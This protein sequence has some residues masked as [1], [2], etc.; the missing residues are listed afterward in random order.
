MKFSYNV[1]DK[2][3]NEI[4]HDKTKQ[5]IIAEL[6]VSE[7]QF[8]RASWNN[9]V[10]M[11]RKWR[12]DKCRIIK[13]SKSLAASI[14][15]R[16]IVDT[17]NSGGTLEEVAEKLGMSDKMKFV[18]QYCADRGYT[19][20]DRGHIAVCENPR[21]YLSGY[22]RQCPC[23]GVTFSCMN[24]DIWVYKIR[25]QVNKNKFFSYYCSY[26]C[27]RK[28]QKKIEVKEKSAKRN[29]YRRDID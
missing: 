16:I 5:E 29:R 4:I 7:A 26:T 6:G 21:E 3:G 20:K 12:V 8:S 25:K 24:P 9:T 22:Y 28:E 18:K 27:Y 13:N 11:N 1:F 10:Y 2:E 23:C 17:L 15:D 19:L 14:D